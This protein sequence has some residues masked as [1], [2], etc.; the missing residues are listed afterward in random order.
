M[1]SPAP[2]AAATPAVPA[3]STYDPTFTPQND[4]ERAAV[5]EALRKVRNDSEVVAKKPAQVVVKLPANARLYV[6]NVYCPVRSFKTPALENGRRYYYTLRAEI[7]QDGE[8][9]AQSQRVVLTAGQ[10]VNVEFTN[11]TTVRTARQN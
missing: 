4:V 11:L 1:V 5:R 7:M 6:D 2:A 8:R 10:N 9:M 3:P